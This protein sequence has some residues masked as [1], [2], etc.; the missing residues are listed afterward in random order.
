[1]E[2]NGNFGIK[3]KKNR[4]RKGRN[5]A[6]LY[7]KRISLSDDGS[8]MRTSTGRVRTTMGLIERLIEREQE[9]ACGLSYRRR[10]DPEG[11]EL[12]EDAG[13][14]ISIANY[15]ELNG[16]GRDGRAL[17]SRSKEQVN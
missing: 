9:G 6:E 16:R 14:K 7:Y 17:A 15:Q 5:A 10:K 1:L 13:E 8:E 11:D 12:P 4:G 3:G 2:K